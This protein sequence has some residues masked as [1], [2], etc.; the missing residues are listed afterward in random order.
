M[1]FS[2]SL[3]AARGRGR[4]RAR[5]LYFFFFPVTDV[6][7][8]QKWTKVRKLKVVFKTLKQPNSW[9]GNILI[10]EFFFSNIK[11]RII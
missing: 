6:N 7:V 10:N 8:L 3:G 4:R 2:F 5:Q 11:N 9:T 1:S